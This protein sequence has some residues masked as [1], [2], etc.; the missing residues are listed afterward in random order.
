ME[1]VNA[2]RN[3]NINGFKGDFVQMVILLYKVIL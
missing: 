2:Y 1:S 3:K